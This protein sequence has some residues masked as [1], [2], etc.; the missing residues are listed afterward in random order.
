MSD[1]IEHS[2]P[3]SDDAEQLC[4]GSILLDN[5]QIDLCM[6]YFGPED[7]YSPFRRHIF[8]AMVELR[9]QGQ[10]IDHVTIIENIK[11]R[12]KNADNWLSGTE[13]VNL[14]FGLP[15]NVNL[16]EA[17]QTIKKHS[18]SRQAIRLANHVTRDLVAGDVDPSEVIAH[19]EQQAMQL[20][21]KLDLQRTEGSTGFIELAQISPVVQAQFEAYHRGEAT[22]VQTGMHELDHILDGGGLQRKGTYVVGGREKSGKTSLALGWC[23]DIVISQHKSA[24]IVTLEMSKEGIFKR[25]YSQYTGI[26]YYMFRPGFYDT[27]LD[28]PYTRAI[29]GLAEFSKFPFRVSDNLF[30]M[31]SIYRHCAKAI[32]LGHKPGNTPVGVIMLDYLQLIGM[33]DS[34]LSTVERVTRVSRWIKMLASDLDVPVIVMSSLNRTGLSDEGREPDVDNLRDS[35]SIAFDAEAVVFVHN[36]SY[37]PGKPYVQKQITDY[38]LILS[39]Q[40]NGPTA[41]INMK[42]IGP[43]MQFITETDYNKYQSHKDGMPMSKGQQVLQEREVD[44]LWDTD[45]ETRGGP[46]T[47]ISDGDDDKNV[48]GR[49]SNDSWDWNDDVDDGWDE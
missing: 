27:N 20:S 42:L 41:R 14:T 49:G 39:R 9:Q 28:N 7:L 6:K 11:A 31:E 43:Y 24:L 45:D 8:A 13:I 2:L 12:D 30:T 38:I 21:T 10:V 37:I 23:G 35:G 26:P 17:A 40:R 5:E 22:G 1:Q 33:D 32:E 44:D 46:N 4:L 47:T 18:I 19:L 16:T 48:T 34:R 3:N 36:P 25:L 15:Y 29:Q